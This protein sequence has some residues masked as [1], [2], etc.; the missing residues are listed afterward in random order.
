MVTSVGMSVFATDCILPPPPDD[1]M[2][3]LHDRE[4]RVRAFRLGPDR[5]LIQGALRDQ[6]PPRLYLQIDPGVAAFV[7]RRPADFV[8]LPDRAEL[9]PLPPFAEQ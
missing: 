5:I 9:P 2:P 8:P 7:E 1:A 3:V 6:K 4:Y